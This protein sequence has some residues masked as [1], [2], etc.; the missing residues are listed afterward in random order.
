MHKQ[1]PFFMLQVLKK[2]KNLALAFP[3]DGKP[4][5]GDR[6][7]V[8][9]ITDLAE[10]DDGTFVM[11]IGSDENVTLPLKEGKTSRG[12]HYISLS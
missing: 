11:R 7:A 2:S 12:Q 1:Q 9:I 3:M 10:N 6:F 5:V 8:G 4:R